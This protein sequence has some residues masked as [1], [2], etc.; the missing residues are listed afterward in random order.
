MLGIALLLIGYGVAGLVGGAIP[1]NRAWREPPH[2]IAIYVESNGIHTDLIVPKVAGGV[3]WRGIFPAADL[4][5]PDYAG[6]DHLAIGWGNRRFFLETPSWRDVRPATVIAAAI[7]SDSNLLHV[8]HI[9]APRTLDADTRRVLLTPGQYR[10][11]SAYIR[12]T[13]MPGGRRHRGYFDYDS[14]YEARGHYDAAHDCNDWTGAALRHAGV[15]MGA[16]TPFPTTVLWW[17]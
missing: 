16:W 17:F 12:S 1:V 10:R 8:E 7:G 4:R 2:G 9:P 6:F 5:D 3:D 13:I 15:R 11:L 14:F